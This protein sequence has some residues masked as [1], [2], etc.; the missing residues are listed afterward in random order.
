MKKY[1]VLLRGINVSG[2]NKIPMAEL[3][4]LLNDLGFKNVQR[5]I[6]SGNII[7]ESKEG[8]SITCNKIKEGIQTKFG[9]DIPVIARTIPKWKK[10]IANY[11][12][13]TDNTKIVA[14]VFLNRKVYETKIDVKDTSNDKYLIQNDM[15]YIYCETGF[16]K[17]KLSN[18]LFERKLNVTA[19]TRNYNT[20]LKLLELAK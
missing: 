11:P 16:A 20:T 7:L 1:I 6:Q 12:F 9:L 18:N 2:K 10:A 8:K 19:T 13:S 4:G 17:T 5:Y 15:I 3:R 14:F